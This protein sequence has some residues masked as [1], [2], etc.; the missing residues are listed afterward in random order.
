MNKLLASTVES[1][2]AVVVSYIALSFFSPALGIVVSQTEVLS[3]VIIVVV[4]VLVTKLLPFDKGG[5]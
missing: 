4:T 1:V 5:L 2:I 3:T